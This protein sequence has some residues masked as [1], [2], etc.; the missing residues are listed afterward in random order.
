MDPASSSGV[1]TMGL[2]FSEAL[3]WRAGRPIAIAELMRRLQSLGNELQ[4][5]DQDEGDDT[6][7][8]SFVKV[9]KELADPQLLAHKD[10]GVRAWTARC[11]VDLLRLCAPNAPFT[12][13]Q[14][15]AIFEM[16][17]RS[18]LPALG[19]PSNAYNPQHMY[20]LESLATVKSIL[21]VTD[22]SG[23]DS[24]V[25]SIFATFFDILSNT[26]KAATG[27]QVA[28]AV[29]NNMTE[30]MSILVE[31]SSILPQDVVDMI[32]A[33][34][35]RADPKIIEL[36]DARPKKQPP[37]SNFQPT[38][39]I[40]ELP[41]AY[42]A[43][44]T[45]CNE[46]ADRMARE[47]SKYFSDII[48]DASAYTK[49]S[50]GDSVDAEDLDASVGPDGQ[51]L[52]ELEK[53]H[54]LLRE[55]WRA[56]P[57]V[58]QNVIPQLEQE[59]SAENVQLRVLATETLG[60]MASGIGAAGP[61]P[62][63]PMDPTAYPPLNLS[64]P[65][66]PLPQRGFM[67]VPSVPN[68][69]LRTH[70]LAYAKF[71]GRRQDKSAVVRVAW[72]TGIGRVLTTAAGSMGMSHDDEERL[73]SDI[74]K[75]LNDSDE[76]V[77]VA[78]VGV[79]GLLSL[80]DV[81]NKLGRAGG[82]DVVGSVLGN[83]AERIKDRKPAVRREAMTVF[84]R[85]WGVAAGEIASGNEQ[86]TTVLGGVPSKILNTY[87]TNDREI[88]VQMDRALFEILLPFSYPP[89]K[90]K[91]ARNQPSQLQQMA[92]SQSQANS[93]GGEAVDPAATRVERMLVLVKGL[94]ERAR[95]IFFAL[96]KR[97][98]S[99]SRFMDAYIQACEDYN[100]CSSHS[101]LSDDLD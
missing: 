6:F 49:E 52:A 50:R 96:S 23:S 22:Q 82:V 84:A 74:A 78:S 75:M 9:A 30:I 56:C 100:V 29:N 83:L 67:A 65:L 53:A 40:R 27:E 54:R 16:I 62:T 11:I 85:L 86:V 37:P 39:A 5:L 12:E 80:K 18:I 73:V 26:S 61:P 15:K 33:Q 101:G 51:D 28:K 72:I 48:V 34:F 21:L 35:L 43:A 47:I 76:R 7:K 24:L 87:Y 66:E 1:S 19:D 57:S 98:V 38:L 97:Q 89:V 55:L 44:K 58:L 77:R 2:K 99:T 8:E 32:V 41:P 59:L 79:I 93:D 10:R 14:L 45:I 63:A 13:K 94:D 95:M 20:V 91:A 3:S 68:S 60:D 69:F 64:S 81:V 88:I 25:K 46:R 70:P 17:I 92:S 71:L 31:E 90:A 42:N 4:S 36:R